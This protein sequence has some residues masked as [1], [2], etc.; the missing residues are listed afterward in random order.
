ML[1]N[2]FIV[3]VLNDFPKGRNITL[4]TEQNLNR[5]LY[6]LNLCDI[7]SQLTDYTVA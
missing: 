2:N 6:L 5:E 7:K 3:S 4:P 1:L